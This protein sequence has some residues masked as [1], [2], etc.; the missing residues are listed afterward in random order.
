MMKSIATLCLVLGY[1]QRKDCQRWLG[2][3]LTCCLLNNMIW[4]IK[5][6]SMLVV[7][8]FVLHMQCAAGVKSPLIQ[9]A[10]L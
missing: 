2:K 5:D 4:L 9:H 8:C 6:I 3:Y 1:C 10:S 7:L